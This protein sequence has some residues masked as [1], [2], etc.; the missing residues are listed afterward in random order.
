MAQDV[1]CPPTHKNSLIKSSSAIFKKP[2]LAVPPLPSP[3]LCPHNPGLPP[4]PAQCHPVS[5]LAIHCCH[6]FLLGASLRCSRGPR[7]LWAVEMTEGVGGR[8]RDPGRRV[9]GW[10]CSPEG[11]EVCRG[12]AGHSCHGA[13]A[14]QAL[15]GSKLGEHGQCIREVG[16]CGRGVAR[17]THHLRVVVAVG[18]VAFLEERA[19][20]GPFTHTL[21]DL[22][23][24]GRGKEPN[25]T[26]VQAEA[27]RLPRSRPF[28]M[29]VLF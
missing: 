28:S 25:R 15:R 1:Y 13:A 19:E 18:N 8:G 14:L 23:W 20:G 27:C 26:A 3:A 10:R 6:G 24:W 22:Q 11:A 17:S 12:G 21:S 29:A 7:G 9:V 4:A 5:S 16:R 2:P